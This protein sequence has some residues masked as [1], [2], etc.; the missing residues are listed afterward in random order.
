VAP[1][2]SNDFHVEGLPAGDYLA[3]AWLADFGVAN[4]I[5]FNTPE[6]LKR[7]GWCMERIRIGESETLLLTVRNVL[8]WDAFELK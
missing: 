5:P 2:A 7:F 3:F 8:P 1:D 6:F 4:E